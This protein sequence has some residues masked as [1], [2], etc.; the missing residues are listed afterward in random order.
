MQNEIIILIIGDDLNSRNPPQGV[1]APTLG[2]INRNEGN[3]WGEASPIRNRGVR[4]FVPNAIIMDEEV[5]YQ[6]ILDEILQH[7][8]D[9]LHE[10]LDSKILSFYSSIMKFWR[11]NTFY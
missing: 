11:K 5:E 3:L 6:S 7:K 2:F 9:V 4:P 10:D 8:K 1:G